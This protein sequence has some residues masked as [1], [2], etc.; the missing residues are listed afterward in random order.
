[1]HEFRCF[2][3]RDFCDRSDFN[4][5]GEFVDGHED[6]PVAARIYSEWTH[7]IEAPHG[8]GPGWG[9]CAQGLSWQVLF[10]GKELTSFASL[11]EVFGVSHGRGPVEI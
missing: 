9:N 8:E 1:L 7:R 2:F 5:I 4:P 6:V 3:R 10:F 11:D